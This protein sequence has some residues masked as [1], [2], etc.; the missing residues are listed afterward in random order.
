M[1]IL[2]RKSPI[3]SKCGGGVMRFFRNASKKVK[4]RSMNILN[5]KS[6][7]FSKCG[8][9]VMRF[10]RNASKKVKKRSMFKNGCR[11]ES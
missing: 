7:I 11:V 3:F 6:P 5:R 9:G 10:F 8:G 1:N 2:N 4:K